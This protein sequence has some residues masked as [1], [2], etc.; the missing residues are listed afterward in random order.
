MALNHYLDVLSNRPGMLSHT[1]RG[2]FQHNTVRDY[3]A[4]VE[5]FRFLGMKPHLSPSAK[6]FHDYAYSL[7]NARDNIR[8]TSHGMPVVLHVFDPYLASLVVPNHQ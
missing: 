3:S 4:Q 8:C 2:L 6:I 1:M 5:A 7:F